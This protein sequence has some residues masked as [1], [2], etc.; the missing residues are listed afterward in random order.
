MRTAPEVD[1]CVV[2]LGGAGSMAAYALATAGR[3]VC[4]FEAGPTRSGR[5][6]V[7]DEL[8]SSMV[9]NSWGRP[10]FNHEVP[11]WRPNGRS[12]P[13]PIPY[14]QRM[15]NGVGGSSLAYAT[16]SFRYHP[17]DFRTKSSTLAR[18]GPE[19]VPFGANL[20][21][22]PLTYEDLEPYYDLA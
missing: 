8:E 20:A 21:D 6:Y 2:G 3:D 5:E 11:T 14:T 1:V 12:A 9:R 4:A 18:Y 17:D 10:K 16:I 15:A 22:W 7:M 13:Q 19:A